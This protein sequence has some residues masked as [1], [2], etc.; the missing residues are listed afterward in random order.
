MARNAEMASAWLN[1]FGTMQ[2]PDSSLEFDEI[3][4]I[5]FSGLTDLPFGACVLL[6]LPDSERARGW[7]KAIM[8]AH[9]RGDLQPV[10]FGDAPAAKRLDEDSGAAAV[11]FP[12]GV[13]RGSG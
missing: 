9:A 6:R 10:S 3:Q 8:P 7:L 2:R 12:P 1:C 13:W 5:V 4:T 11:V